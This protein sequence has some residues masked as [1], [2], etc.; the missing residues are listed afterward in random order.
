MQQAEVFFFCLFFKISFCVSAFFFLYSAL[1]PSVFSA[2]L[3]YLQVD[4]SDSQAS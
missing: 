2:S 3:F 1:S 4:A